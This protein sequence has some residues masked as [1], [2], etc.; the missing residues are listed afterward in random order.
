M[1]HT[2]REGMNNFLGDKGK[3]R[4]VSKNGGILLVNPEMS[5][6][7]PILR[8]LVDQNKTNNKACMAGVYGHSDVCLETC[9]L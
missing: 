6:Y 8:L 4:G 9:F 2:G 1:Q 5:L 3:L 7:C